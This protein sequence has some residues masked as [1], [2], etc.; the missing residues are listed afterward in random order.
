MSAPKAFYITTAISYPNG[1]PHIGHAYEAITTDV[2]ARFK[3]LDGF[4]VRF[5]TGVDDHGQKMAQT[6]KAKGTTPQALADEMAPKFQAMDERLD[7]S[8]DDFIR[9]T[10]ARHERA[11]QH[12]WEK[13]AAKGD[14]YTGKYAGWYSVRDEAFYDEDELVAGEDGQKRAPGTGT[15]VE[16]MEEETYFFRLSAYQEKL[17]ALYEAKP[18]F[19]Q[20]ASRRNEIVAFV[21]RGLNDLSISRARTKLDWGV[22]VP[23]DPDHVMYVWIDALTNYITGLGYPDTEGELFKRYWPA[24]AHII[25][26][27]IVRFHAVIWP[28]MLMAADIALPKRVFGHGFLNVGGEK[29]SKSVGNVIDPFTITD[30]YGVDPIRYFFC[31]EVSFGN[32]GSYSHETVVN[33]INADLANDLGNLAQRSLSMIAK[34]CEGK[35]PAPGDFTDEDKALL[36]AA[37][38]LPEGARAHMERLEIHAYAGGVFDVVGEANRYFA[39]QEPWALKKS[40]PARMATVLY[41]TAEVVR[42]CAIMLQPVMPASIAKLLDLLAVAEDARGFVH[43]ASGALTPGTALPAPSGVFPRFVEPE[44]AS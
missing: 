33:R 22:G 43:V 3:R 34:N 12:I 17:L 32:D 21:K 2:I 28:A 24:D 42:R 14:I 18:D 10:E 5:L 8:N 44:A 4:D 19:I 40:D 1:P 29:M 23:G 35:V 30:T 7:I 11:C 27:D 16:W 6:A 13:I 25:G 38:A 37:A 15:P 41:V 9:T 31:R 39:G 36:E 20:P 26:K